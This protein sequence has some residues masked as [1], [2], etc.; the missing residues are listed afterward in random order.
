MHGAQSASSMRTLRA[1]GFPASASPL[2]MLPLAQVVFGRAEQ[3]W[4]PFQSESR[5]RRLRT[6]GSLHRLENCQLLRTF[7]FDSVRVRLAV[8]LLLV[9]DRA[10]RLVVAGAARLFTV[11][12]LALAADEDLA[13]KLTNLLKVAGP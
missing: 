10:F 3:R 1:Q 4:S 9:G 2:R 6:S 12:L 5:S 7:C 8:L 13:N 11:G